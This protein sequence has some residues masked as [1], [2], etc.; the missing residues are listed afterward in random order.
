MRSIFILLA[1]FI[2]LGA[3]SLSA[4]AF[5]LGDIGTVGRVVDAGSKIS[6][7]YEELTPEQEYYVGRSVAARILGLH[8]ETVSQQKNDYLNRI[9]NYLA[10][11]SSRPETFGGYHAII[12]NSD[13]ANAYS[14]P[15]GFILIS[16]ALL[17]HINSEDE[18]AAI[19]AHEIAHV[20]LK[21]GLA[22]IKKSSLA[23]AAGILGKEAARGTGY[24]ADQ[25]EMLT[26][27]F[28][29]SV[30]D[31]V[32]TVTTSGYSRSQELEA[33]QEA[34]KILYR[35]GYSTA[36]LNSIL[37]IQKSDIPQESDNLVSNITVTHPNDDKR[38][39]E[40]DQFIAD[41]KLDSP[42]NPER[43]ARFREIL[44]TN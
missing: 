40:L 38:L 23:E 29:S 17:D 2:T 6:D 39:K 20:A 30:N 9:V 26:A 12:F 28:G 35:A 15:G 33:D 3:F 37:N 18:L 1:G 25:L 32:T 5:D 11:H 24:S 42:I 10:W 31:I 7:S 22:S 36:A 44:K 41:E 21:H 14:A 8:P 19:A 43:T 34:A 27:S 13:V 16:S 4:T